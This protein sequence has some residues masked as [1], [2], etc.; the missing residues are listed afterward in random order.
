MRQGR[1]KEVVASYR[2]DPHVQRLELGLLR[3]KDSD[4][5]RGDKEGGQDGQAGSTGQAF[6]ANCHCP[7]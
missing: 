5:G 7:L 6:M 3:N 2:G 1:P 4:K